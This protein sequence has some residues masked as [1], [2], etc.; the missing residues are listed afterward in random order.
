LLAVGGRKREFCFQIKKVVLFTRAS[1]WLNPVREIQPA[2]RR[3]KTKHSRNAN[4]FCHSV[5]RLDFDN[6]DVGQPGLPPKKDWPELAQT[7]MDAVENRRAL[8]MVYNNRTIA[9][10]PLLA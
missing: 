10:R 7:K 3:Q 9:L 2:W 8:R 4:R 6:C 1:F 5:R